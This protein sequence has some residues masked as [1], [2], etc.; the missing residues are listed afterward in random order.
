M[1]SGGVKMNKGK[2]ALSL[3]MEVILKDEKTGETLVSV[4]ER[5]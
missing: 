1:P 4:M 2:P 3:S 5:V